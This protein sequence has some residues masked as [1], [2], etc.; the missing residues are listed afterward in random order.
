M[1]PR[2]PS[3]PP[4]PVADSLVGRTLASDVLHRLRADLVEGALAPGMRLR[5]AELR[6]HY[7]VSF[8]TL[9]EALAHLVREGLVVAEGQ[10]GFRVAPVSARDLADLID[11]QTMIECRIMELAV[12]KG[13]QAWEEGVRRGIEAL[14][15]L[16][17]ES[18]AGYHLEP[19][20]VAEHRSFHAALAAGCASPT[21]LELRALLYERW[22]RY[23]QVL[24]RRGVRLPWT[25]DTHAALADAA[26]ARDPARAMHLLQEQIRGSLEILMAQAEH[27]PAQG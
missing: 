19:R 20:W 22:Q 21:L 2:L 12:L 24:V 23:R 17:A 5:F 6:R 7:G 18:G 9:R 14:E 13:D 15:A 27:L 1:S 8:G 26:L 4:R 10:R 11:A 16:R 25:R 3:A